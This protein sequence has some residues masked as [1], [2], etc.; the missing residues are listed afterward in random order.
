TVILHASSNQGVVVIWYPGPVVA[1][2]LP[3]SVSGTYTAVAQLNGC[4]VSDSV[5]VTLATLPSVSFD[6]TLLSSC[7]LDVAAAPKITGTIAS[8]HWSDNTTGST[9]VLTQSGNYAVTVTTSQGCTATAGVN[10]NKVCIGAVAT[11]TPDTILV[12]G[13]T[14]LNVTTSITGTIT[15]SWQPA[16]SVSNPNISNPVASPKY[17]TTYTVFVRDTVSGCID[18]AI[19]DVY[20]MYNADFG[21]PNVF[22]PNNDGNNDTWFVINQAGLVTVEDIK[23]Y[24]RWGELVFDSHRDGTIEWNGYY[25]NKLQD[26]GNYVY[27]IKLKI[28]ASGQEKFIKGNLA[29]LW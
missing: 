22:T 23:V 11:S 27:N 19:T 9:D 1:D 14:Q 16:D 26:M 18:T 7:C 25:R 29:L 2:T 13:S 20:V 6:D 12:E 8:Y 28:N 10:F 24:N 3:V 15:Y 21:I 4:Y 5:N 17:P